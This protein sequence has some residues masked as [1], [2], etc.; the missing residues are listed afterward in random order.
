MPPK[1]SHQSYLV[2]RRWRHGPLEDRSPQAGCLWWVVGHP[3]ATCVPLPWF[4]EQPSLWALAQT[5][6]PLWEG[7]HPP[8]QAFPSLFVLWLELT[9]FIMSDQA[10]PHR[11]FIM[12]VSSAAWSAFV[13][14]NTP[15]A[16]RDPCTFAHV[17]EDTSAR[18]L[19]DKN[20]QSQSK[21]QGHQ[22]IQLWSSSA[23][24][25]WQ[26]HSPASSYS[27]WLPKNSLHSF[28]LQVQ[29]LISC[30]LL[31]CAHAYYRGCH[32]GTAL[33]GRNHSPTSVGDNSY[34]TWRQLAEEMTKF[35]SYYTVTPV[36]GKIRDA[37]R[38][39]AMG[40]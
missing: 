34:G 25:P 36:L 32:F 28:S 23:P 37:T 8:C 5:S 10:L 39:L 19:P 18:G 15:L 22:K 21:A 6:H 38:P 29:Q 20:S 2:R 31:L 33:A 17:L 13:S 12:S 7:S 11:A 30:H 3:L 16:H 35:E 27:L 26:G 14:R 1:T 40:S 9:H 4:Q 24:G